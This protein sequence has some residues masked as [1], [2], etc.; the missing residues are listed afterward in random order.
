MIE[1]A[2]RQS[3]EVI[4]RYEVENL[5]G[6]IEVTTLEE[7]FTETFV[8]GESTLEAEKS[9]AEEELPFSTGIRSSVLGEK[10]RRFDG[11]YC[12]KSH[13]ESDRLWISYQKLQPANRST[14][15]YVTNAAGRFVCS[16]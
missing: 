1:R 4:H 6:N 10:N 12:R 3:Y 14:Y 16:G 7:T 8:S 5:S 9:R 11:H 15:N 2:E 13:N